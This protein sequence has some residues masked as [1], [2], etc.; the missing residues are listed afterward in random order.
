MIFNALLANL[1]Q[2]STHWWKVNNSDVVE[3]VT[4]ETE[5]ETLIKFRGETE[6]LS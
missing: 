4:S 5:T 6:T 3:T 1:R 2:T